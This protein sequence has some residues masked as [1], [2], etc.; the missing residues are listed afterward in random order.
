MYIMGTDCIFHVL[1]LFSS[2]IVGSDMSL[3]VRL[4][5]TGRRAHAQIG[6][7]FFIYNDLALF[8]L[9]QG[10]FQNRQYFSI[11]DWDKSFC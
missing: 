10:L 9:E 5:F 7:S 6:D 4:A 2:S 8:M 11:N 3:H 1:S